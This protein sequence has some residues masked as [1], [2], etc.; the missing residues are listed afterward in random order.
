M[1]LKQVTISVILAVGLRA[2][3]ALDLYLQAQRAERKQEYA[4]AYL[5]Y[6]QAAALDPS[7]RKAWA[8]SQALRTKAILEAQIPDL[9]GR[10][11][12]RPIESPGPSIPI[13]TS[14]DWAEMAKLRPPPTLKASPERKDFNLRLPPRDLFREVAKAYGLGVAIDPDYPESGAPVAFRLNQVGYREALRAAEAAT[15]SF[16]IPLSE[17]MILVAKDNLQERSE[18]DP[19]VALTVP[20]PEPFSVQE[21]Q[22]LARTVQQVLE[23]VKFGMDTGRRVVVFRDR[24]L[25]VLAA[26]ALL[27]Q[28]LASRAEVTVEL[29]FLEVDENSTLSY[30]LRTQTGTTLAA[31][32]KLF[33]WVTPFL[34]AGYRAMG[35]FG[36]GRSLFGVG[37]ADAELFASLTRSSARSLMRA[38]IRSVDGMPAQL[39][40]GDR[41]PVVTSGYYGPITG[42]GQVYRPPPIFNFED[43]GV[44]FKITPRVHSQEELTLQVE[45]E[46]KVLTGEAL[47]GIPVISSRRYSSTVRLRTSQWAVVA[48]L[49]SSSEARSISGLYG[50]AALPVLGPLVRQNEKQK[51][52]REVLVV[53]R[54]KIVTLPPGELVRTRGFWL[55]SETRTFCPL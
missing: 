41:Y 45:S 40:V 32:G 16:V 23:I 31:F 36:S 44:V 4:R 26:Q 21:A 53:L 49:L 25:K 13:L 42:P 39:H 19:M 48:G 47:N 10:P 14:Q 55:G 27:A 18:V 50:L 52:R 8:K 28:L 38:E 22:E 9:I 2:Q 15:Q 17:R 51:D 12:A 24:Y 37:I 7:D 11:V 29:E 30:G 46:F 5:L 1:L 54:P 6:A 34:P 35:V 43:L 3:S 20:I 33:P